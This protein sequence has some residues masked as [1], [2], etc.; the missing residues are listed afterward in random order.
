MKAWLSW[1]WQWIKYLYDEYKPKPRI[2]P[3][4]PTKPPSRA[5]LEFAVPPEHTLEVLTLYDKLRNTKG[6]AVVERHKMWKKIQ[7]VIPD[8]P[9][10]TWT[11][12]VSSATRV[13]IRET[14]KEDD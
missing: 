3:I 13:V 8:I 1:L 14:K 11:V 2:R 6:S 9:T 5:L 4:K 7:E 10:G 12:D